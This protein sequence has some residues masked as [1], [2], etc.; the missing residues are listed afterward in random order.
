MRRRYRQRQSRQ[1]VQY[2]SDRACANVKANGRGPSTDALVLLNAAKV[3]NF[4]C[5]VLARGDKPQ[6]RTG[7]WVERHLASLC[8]GSKYVSSCRVAKIQRCRGFATRR[9]KVSAELPR[10]HVAW[11]LKFLAEWVGSMSEMPE[12]HPLMESIQTVMGN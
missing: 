7:Y 3:S 8:L 6:I 9:A 1:F 2:L 11:K 10:A 4:S 5:S 12:L